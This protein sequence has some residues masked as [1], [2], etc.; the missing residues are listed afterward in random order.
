MKIVL[1]NKSA[2]PPFQFCVKANTWCS[3]YYA[4]NDFEKAMNKARVL[5][6]AEFPIVNVMETYESM[7]GEWMMRYIFTYIRGTCIEREEP[8]LH[9]KFYTD[10]GECLTELEYGK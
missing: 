6:L 10:A 8:A 3:D 9:A 1:K 2:K 4:F 5:S 7:F